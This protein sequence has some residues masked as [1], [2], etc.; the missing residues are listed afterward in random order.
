M[1]LVPLSEDSA[2][3]PPSDA[4]LYLTFPS[5]NPVENT[6]GRALIQD[7]LL[8]GFFIYPFYALS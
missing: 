5:E 2:A 1:E 7:H 6:P 4:N 3:P 8:I